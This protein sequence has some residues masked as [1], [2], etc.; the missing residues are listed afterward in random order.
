MS[1]QGHKLQVDK[2]HETTIFNFKITKTGWE[3]FVD[4]PK[5][6]HKWG[7]YRVEAKKHTFKGLLTWKSCLRLV[8]WGWADRSSFKNGR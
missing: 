4:V 2:R 5:K 8:F 1:I 6:D 7:M 3:T